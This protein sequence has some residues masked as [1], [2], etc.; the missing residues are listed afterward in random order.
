MA[1]PLRVEVAG[2]LYHVIVRGN[3]RR[4]V[5]RDDRDRERYLARLAVYR[6]KFEF[7]L[8]A[9]CLMDNHVH[10][11]IETS[12]SMGSVLEDGIIGGDGEAGAV[13]GGWWSVPRH[14]AR[15]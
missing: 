1:R 8:L 13:G 11:A 14:R 9:Y 4:N 3:E 7:Q 6:E 2:G 12:G 5:F 10:L 15:E